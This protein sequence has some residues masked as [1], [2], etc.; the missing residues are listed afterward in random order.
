MSAFVQHEK[1]GLVY[2]TAPVI[3]AKHAF[4]TRYGGVSEGYLASL[5]LGLTAATSASVSWKTTASWA[6]RWA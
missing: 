6:G 5:N 4:T 1:G 2:M 3:S